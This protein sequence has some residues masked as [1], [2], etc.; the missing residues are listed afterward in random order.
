MA[1]Q[2]QGAYTPPSEPPLSFDA[3]QPVRG[4]SPMPTTL[5][6]SVVLLAIVGGGG[7]MFLRH[8]AG[9]SASRCLAT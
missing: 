8:G 5:I 3:R 1:Y 4:A 2:E 9:P 6:A 7:I